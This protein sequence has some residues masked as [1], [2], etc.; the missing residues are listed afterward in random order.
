MTGKILRYLLYAAMIF[1]AISGLYGGVILLV[2]PSGSKLQL[3]ISLLEN[4][5]FTNYF[6]PGLTL[7]LLLGLVP[8]FTFYGLISKRKNRIASKLNL[9]NKKHWAWTFSIYSGIILIT[10]IDIQVMLIGGG[11]TIQ[12]VYALLGVLILILTLTPE[13]NRSYKL[14]NKK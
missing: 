11:Y 5:M 8:S 1:L 14:K 10:W 6:I 12:T 13:I 7:L 4:T 3:S 9:Y 2:D